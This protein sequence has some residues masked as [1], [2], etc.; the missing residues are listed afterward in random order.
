M[1]E[2]RD[3]HSGQP[4][5]R[6]LVVLFFAMVTGGAAI[7]ADQTFARRAGL[8]AAGQLPAGLPRPH[9]HFRTTISY[10]TPYVSRYARP[11]Y[12]YETPQVLF[13]PT[14]VSVP[15]IPPL[16]SVP[17]LPGYYGWAYSYE[18]QGPYYAAP[19]IGYW[20]RLPYAC[21]VYGYC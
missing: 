12:A 13:T 17:L 7:S 19:D 10:G 21:G 3:H 2:Y 18:Y 15:Y 20:D 4:M 14:Y 6:L 11:F 9:Y 5:L 8:R 16:V 1:A